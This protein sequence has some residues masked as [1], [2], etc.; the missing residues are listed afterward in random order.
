MACIMLFFNQGLLIHLLQFHYLTSAS[1]HSSMSHYTASARFTMKQNDP[2]IWAVCQKC[3]RKPVLPPH[4]YRPESSIP[5][6][7]PLLMSS[8]THTI[9]LACFSKISCKLN[10]GGRLI[11]S[12]T[13]DS[14]H[15][16]MLHHHN[17]KVDALFPWNGI[18]F[19]DAKHQTSVIESFLSSSKNYP[20]P[21]CYDNAK[22]VVLIDSWPII[23]NHKLSEYY[24][25]KTPNEVKKLLTPALSGLDD[26]VRTIKI[27]YE[28]M[29][30]LMKAIIQNLP[31]DNIKN[32]II[33]FNVSTEI[34]NELSE[35]LMDLKKENYLLREKIE[36]MTFKEREREKE[37][38]HNMHFERLPTTQYMQHLKNQVKSSNDMF[39][40]STYNRHISPEQTVPKHQS[41]IYPSYEYP[42]SKQRDKN[43]IMITPTPPSRLSLRTHSR[44]SI[45]SSTA[46]NKDEYKMDQNSQYRKFDEYANNS[47]YPPSTMIEPYSK[48][49]YES[50]KH[51][52]KSSKGKHAYKQSY[53]YMHENK[54]KTGFNYRQS[55][56]N[57]KI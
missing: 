52:S 6:N 54:K 45:G 18:Q 56:N 57:D 41:N 40:H 44:A 13:N 9:C 26:V 32:D 42:Y 49:K 2:A 7:L 29:Q 39:T 35:Q 50:K 43:P 25:S 22:F 24:S 17:N 38:K 20:C 46:L 55:Q 8:C 5:L 15:N 11:N 31:P 33:D 14:N 21:I 34:D 23:S 36:R 48:Y 3:H 1:S 53:S 27:Q 4:K 28:H 51:S 12:P 47:R 30:S 19:I 10:V 16:N 37:I